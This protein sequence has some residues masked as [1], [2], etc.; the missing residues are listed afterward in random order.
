MARTGRRPDRPETRAEI[1][2]AA[3]AAFADRGY[4]GASIR[5]IATVAGVDPALVHHYFGT[6]ERLF[7]TVLRSAM[8]PEQLLPQVFAGAPET[9]GERL[10]GRF[11]AL[12]DGG[13]GATVSALL[14]TAVASDQFGPLVRGRVVPTVV[15]E[16]VSRL[17]VDRVEAAVRTTLVASQLSG[18]VIARYVLRLEPMASA[19]PDWVAAAIGPTVQR[20]L[21][22]VLPQIPKARASSPA[23]P[24]A[25][26]VGDS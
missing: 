24:S 18:L 5:Q 7:H 2:A 22:G 3:R 14:R 8:D 12:W 11:L 25:T 6:K 1:V 19:P 9:L 10:V 21:T 4:L 23:P 13:A 16:V 17:G 20:Y 15:G 26:G